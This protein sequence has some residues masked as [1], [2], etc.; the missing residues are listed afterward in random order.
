MIKFEVYPCV[1]ERVHGHVRRMPCAAR[2]DPSDSLEEYAH[3]MPTLPSAY[4]ER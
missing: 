1:A 3:D 2:G 4:H